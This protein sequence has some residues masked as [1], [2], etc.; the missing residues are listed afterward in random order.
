M[1]DV[2]KLSQEPGS[3][4]QKNRVK[5][6]LFLF[7]LG[8]LIGLAL[9]S[10]YMPRVIAWYAEPPMPMGVTCTSSIRWALEKMQRAQLYA[11]GVGGVFG[12]FLGYRIGK[13]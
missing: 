4:L 10:I 7:I 1:N 2:N 11:I 12:A 13:R 8:V 9:V 3:S 6:I 5:P